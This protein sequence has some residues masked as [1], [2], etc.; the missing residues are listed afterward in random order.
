MTNLTSQSIA[1]A[2]M[3]THLPRERRK[4]RVKQAVAM[5]DELVGRKDEEIKELRQL[6]HQV[7]P[8]DCVMGCNEVKFCSIRQGEGNQ[9]KQCSDYK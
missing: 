3:P 7:L 2:I 4:E 8:K 5:I 9:C 6:V 1:E